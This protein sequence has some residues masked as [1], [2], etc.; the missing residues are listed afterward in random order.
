MF[1]SPLR[2]SIRSLAAT[3]GALACAQV[4]ELNEQILVLYLIL[5]GNALLLAVTHASS[6]PFLLL[7]GMPVF[8]VLFSAV[9]MG[10]F[11]RRKSVAIEPAWAVRR[12]RIT[13]IL[14]F[15]IGSVFTAWCLALLPYGDIYARCHVAFYMSVTVISMMFCLRHAP[16]AVVALQA[17]VVAPLAVVLFRSG[18]P[19]LVAIA[20]NLLAASCT[21]LMALLKEFA[22]FRDLIS[23]REELLRRQGELE[24]L[25]DEN[26]RLADHD[27]LT[28]LPNRRSFFAALDATLRDAS[29][30][31]ERFAVALIDL[32]GF[33]AVND[34]HGHS[35]G[36]RLLVEA[37]QRLRRIEAPGIFIAR[38]GGDEF[39]AILRGGLTDADL[40]AQ[41]ERFCRALKGRY[42]VSEVPAFVSGSIGLVSFP[43]G[44]Q[45]AE[46]LFERADFALY[47]AKHTRKG[48]AAVFS[49]AHESMIREASLVEH[50]L[51]Q[52]DLEREL[53]LVFQPIVDT[54][55]G[56]L[57][58]FEALARWQSPTLGAVR[59]DVFIRAAERSRTVGDLTEILFRKALAAIASWPDD[60][61]LAFNLSALDIE[62]DGC[63]GSILAL[64]LAS[65]VAPS[66]I[67][68]EI[69]ETAMMRELDPA[70]A[71]LR[72]LRD[73]G[74]RISLDDFGTG[75]SSLSQLHVLKPDKVKIDRSFVVALGTRPEACDVVRAALELC[76]NLGS[77]TVIEGVETAE[78]RDVLQRLGGR[79]MQGF[80]F[81]RP[82]ELDA[83]RRVIDE[84]VRRR[85]QAET[86]FLERKNQRTSVH[87]V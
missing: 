67:D 75:Y 57:T 17:T 66:R 30:G 25:S 19:A 46:Q 40:V 39:A 33:K 49:A 50:T 24:R 34:V 44:A 22:D 29:V 84:E 42:L 16:R 37:S 41:G 64:A 80:F 71:S 10:A 65:G 72:R 69:T 86:F 26:L 11:L 4:A 48:S 27:S 61:R 28:N 3:D 31:S 13:T 74:F 21:I 85:A 18:N 51:E 1:G 43:D 32:D 79:L 63:V 82:L 53:R 70:L 52:A 8:L 7:W 5:T 2:R 83:A 20:I 73:A 58:G 56:A 60:F 78:Q 59:P 77:D 15:V 35:A 87:L 62:Q 23:S 6:T 9:R 55:S 14:C 54:V 12:L 76:R 38:L 81:S 45:T 68:L 47:H 36:D